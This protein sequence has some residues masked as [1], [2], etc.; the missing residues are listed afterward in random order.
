MKKLKTLVA[1]Q[2]RD[3]LDLSFLSNKKETFRTLLFGLLKFIAVAAIC[4]VILFLFKQYVF[5]ETDIPKIIILVFSFI[6]VLMVISS[7]FELMNSLYFSDDNRVLITFP[8]NTNYIF[9]SKII[10]FYMYQL[11]KNL[12]F[13]FPFLFGCSLFMSIVFTY[14][15]PWFLCLW[16]VLPF[17][18]IIALVVLLAALLSI[19]MMYISRYLKKN[20]IVALITSL[21]A[22]VASIVL[23]V[24]LIK[25]IPENIDLM[26]Q[27]PAISN[28]IHNF[29]L[30]IESKL[31][32]MSKFVYTVLGE[33][34]SNKLNYQIN[35]ISLLKLGIMII[36]TVA[37]FFI[38]FFISK[39]IFFSMMAKNFEIN[40]SNKEGKNNHVHNKYLTFINKEFI[41]NL[42]TI[43]ISLNYLIIY[44]I[45]PILILFLNALY[46]AMDTRKLGDLLIYT[47]NILLICLPLLASNALVATYYSRE[48]RAA[49]IKKTKPILVIYPLLAKLIFNAAFSIPT[50]FASVAIF[51]HSVHFNALEIF[52]LGLAIL[53]LHYGHMVYS[54]MLDIMNPQNE[55]YAT[56]GN[57]DDNPNENK[58]TIVAFI[59]SFVYAIISYKL[60]SEAL[61]ANNIT[62]GVFKL[63]LIS[64]SYFVGIAI[65]FAKRVKAFYYSIQG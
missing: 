32:I 64:G 29:L 21:I 22:L 54:A 41:I 25:L 17:I 44:I 9:V 12:E 7:T 27:W 61:L 24:Y 62:L 65:L 40:K 60:L 56:F 10:V 45:V 35:V 18:F 13:I 55:Q 6:L 39:P 8:V 34:N 63:M 30:A 51:G 52:I 2:L 5:K 37:L 1:I 38:V 47:F 11:K 26:N 4:F 42:R 23:I 16:I 33:Y 14:R 46:K 20:T 28:N 58:S 50:I 15:S 59:L 19:P 31:S 57:T 49:Y 53:F 3:K 48:G 36:T 43:N